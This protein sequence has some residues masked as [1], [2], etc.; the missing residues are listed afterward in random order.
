[1]RTQLRVPALRTAWMMLPGIGADV[2][3]PMAR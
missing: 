1:M 3:A 2:R